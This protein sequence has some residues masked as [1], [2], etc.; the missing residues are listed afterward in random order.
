MI[1]ARRF[2]ADRRRAL[3][4]WSVGLLAMNA[5]SVALY[6]SIRDQTSFEDMIEDL[7]D[8]IRAM[9]G[10]QA[11]ISIL[12]PPGY[13]NGRVFATLFPLI[14]LSFGIGLG[15]RA[16]GGSEDDGTLEL[17]LSNPVPRRRV[18]WER[19]V[20][21]VASVVA[22]GLVGFLSLLVLGPTVGL[23]D[24]ISVGRLAAA[25]GGAVALALLHVGIAF[26]TGALAGRRS[27]ALAVAGS[28]AVGGY[29]IYTLVSS[30]SGLSGLKWITPWYWYLERNL[31]VS[32]L[33][34]QASLLPVVLG[35]AMV[36]IGV[37]G[38]ERRDLH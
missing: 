35:L 1:V 36:A 25:S 13:L 17:M 11:E 12:S 6:P 7:P 9:M 15:A 10:A 20:T 24:G 5:V 21:T 19:A 33:T 22:L 28:V 2:W 38:F 27:I 14:L 18:A 37:V 8:A 30:V 3:A 16:I 26:G 23:L 29:L 4:W 34:L 32:N 31:L